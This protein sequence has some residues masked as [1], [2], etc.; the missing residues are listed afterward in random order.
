MHRDFCF[1]ARGVKRRPGVRAVTVA[2]GTVKLGGGGGRGERREHAKL[3]LNV[4]N[5]VVE[6]LLPPDDG[7][8]LRK[9]TLQTNDLPSTYL[10]SMLAHRQK[11]PSR[12][13]MCE[14]SPSFIFASCCEA[15]KIPQGYSEGGAKPT[16]L[17]PLLRTDC[18][19]SDKYKTNVFSLVV[20]AAYFAPRDKKY[21]WRFSEH[22][23][24]APPL[25]WYWRSLNTASC[26]FSF[27]SV[28][29]LSWMLLIL[30][31]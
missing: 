17:H 30:M 18:V 4:R 11:I 5:P 1:R 9:K 8:V 22:D 13:G 29:S 20:L 27:S 7:S 6:L 3:E 19:Y 21:G 12:I 14:R 15:T 25:T 10:K 23:I 24:P 2:L 26:V 31:R 16:G 28:V